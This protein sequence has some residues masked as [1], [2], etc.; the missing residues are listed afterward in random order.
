MKIAAAF[1]ILSQGVEKAK[2][3]LTGEGWLDINHRCRES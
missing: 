3:G 2:Q 1:F